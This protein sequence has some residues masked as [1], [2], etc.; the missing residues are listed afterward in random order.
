MSQHGDDETSFG[1]ID[2]VLSDA[3]EF[4][5]PIEED[6]EEE[7]EETPEEPPGE[8]DPGERPGKKFGCWDLFVCLT[9][10]LISNCLL[11]VCGRMKTREKRWLWREKAALCLVIFFLMGASGVLTFGLSS[12][13]CS[14]EDVNYPAKNVLSS[15]SQ[16]QFL[17]HGRVYVIEDIERFRR[18]N[19][20]QVAKVFNGDTKELSLY[21]QRDTGTCKPVFPCY[22]PGTGE[23]YTCLSFKDV[24][25]PKKCKVSNK[26]KAGFEWGEVSTQKLLVFNGHV[27]DMRAYF[28]TRNA[29]GSGFVP[30]GSETDRVIRGCMGGDCTMQLS[31]LR[32]E[33]QDCLLKQNTIGYIDTK[34]FGCFIAEAVSVATFICVFGILFGKMFLATVFSW[35]MGRF[36]G[37][38]EKKQK[39]TAEEGDSA[40]LFGESTLGGSGFGA[41]EAGEAA[42]SITQQREKMFSLADRARMNVCILV[43]CYSESEEGMKKTFDSVVSTDYPDDHKLLC[44][45]TDGLV[46]GESN[47]ATTAE[48]VLSLFTVEEETPPVAYIAVAG[49]AKHVN[50][51]RV[52]SGWYEH[53]GHRV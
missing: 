2:D 24:F 34:T 43:T 49:G 22:N 27:L 41:V 11:S 16:N 19:T 13:L 30:Y 23:E 51:A 52:Y 10:F 35:T 9:T 6:S 50:M 15:R 37:R 38:M 5:R 42:Q 3:D 8:E 20:K 40:S 44:V 25:I 39:Q 53:D 47:T 26:T 29:R 45:I 18:E 21:F 7:P 4:A 17:I 28:Y 1:E 32:K 33:E 12:F 46:R 48:V 36:L 14:D 31:F